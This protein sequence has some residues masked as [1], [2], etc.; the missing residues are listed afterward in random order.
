M[1]SNLRNF[2]FQVE[3]SQTMS[4]NNNNICLQCYYKTILIFYIVVYGFILIT[5]PHISSNALITII[6]LKIN[7]SYCIVTYSL[8]S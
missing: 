4:H 5:G 2:D 8:H 7:K 1:V 3:S 6:V